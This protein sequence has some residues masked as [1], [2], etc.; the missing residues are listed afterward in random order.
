M[1][2]VG[3]LLVDVGKSSSDSVSCSNSGSVIEGLPCINTRPSTTTPNERREV[4]GGDK[5]LRTPAL[6][7]SARRAFRISG[8]I[9]RGDRFFRE[10][11][12]TR[13]QSC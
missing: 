4:R 2:V 12:M 10:A 3:I 6:V 5:D 11:F 8:S 13:S 9:V 7:I 1:K